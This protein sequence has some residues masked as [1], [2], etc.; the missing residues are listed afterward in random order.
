MSNGTSNGTCKS[1]FHTPEMSNDIVM[2]KRLPSLEKC[3][4][5]HSKTIF[6][7]QVAFSALKVL[8]ALLGP[9]WGSLGAVLGSLGPSWPVLGP[10]WGLLGSSWGCLGAVLGRLGA[11]LGLSWGHLGSSWA[12]LG[13][14]GADFGWDPKK[15]EK[16]VPRTAPF[17]SPKWPCG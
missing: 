9:S 3:C 10:S 5:L 6:F 11:V 4:F 1:C 15:Y 16:M 12:V 7:E 14:L 13:R 17:W 2:P 8:L